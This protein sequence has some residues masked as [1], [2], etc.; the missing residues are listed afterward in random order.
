M[1]AVLYMPA[2]PD[3][4]LHYS[5]YINDSGRLKNG[6]NNKKKK[7]VTKALVSVTKY[8]CFFLCFIFLWGKNE[9]LDVC[10]VGCF[11]YCSLLWNQ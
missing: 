6:K 3:R 2:C 11:M 8:Q 7:N 9:R 1:T 10:A 4:D 5:P